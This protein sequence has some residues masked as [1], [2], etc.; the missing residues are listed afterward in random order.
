[1]GRVLPVFDALPVPEG[2]FFT[3]SFQILSIKLLV[4]P[5]LM[6]LEVSWS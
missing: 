6:L 4:V 1:M 5:F 2:L 3:V